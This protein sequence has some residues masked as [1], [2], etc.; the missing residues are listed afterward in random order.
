MVREEYERDICARSAVASLVPFR[1]Y[2]GFDGWEPQVR[3]CHA[4]V[5]HWVRHHPGHTAV[6]GWLAWASYGS[7]QIGYTAHSVVRS[8]DGEMFDITP[9][10]DP[11][12]WRGGLITHL[13]DDE[14][15]LAM[16]TLNLE[17]R[18]QGSCPAPALTFDLLCQ[19][20]SLE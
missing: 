20:V 18:C 12:C 8:P 4:N 10:L 11:A 1:P 17:I 5:D 14:S 9:T 15:F 7:N 3:Q 19:N 2:A 6:R 13:G 16:R